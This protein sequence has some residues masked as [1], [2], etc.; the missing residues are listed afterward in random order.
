ME[1]YEFPLIS[2][3]SFYFTFCSCLLFILGHVYSLP[4]WILLALQ[5]RSLD[6]VSLFS[7]SFFLFF[8]SFL[9]FIFRYGAAYYSYLY[10]HSYSSL[11][12][13]HCFKNDP[14]SRFQGDKYRRVMLE[15]GGSVDPKLIMTELVG[16]PDADPS[17][18]L[19]HRGIIDVEE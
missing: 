5:I 15:K 17:A 18:Y 4:R 6:R 9:L 8:T 1:E 7:L 19:R 3:L 16:R 2:F 10:S 13:D 14:L 11:I 12:W